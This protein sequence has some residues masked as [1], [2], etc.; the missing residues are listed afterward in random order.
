MARIRLPSDAYSTENAWHLVLRA[1][2]GKPF[3]EPA[4]VE[5]AIAQLSA[6]AEK[7]NVDVL[8]YCFMSDHARLLIHNRGSQDLVQ[9][10]RHFKQRTGYYFQRQTGRKL[11]QKSFFDRGVR[12]DE[13]LQTTA[14]YIRGNPVTD[15]LADEAGQYEWA[16]S[17]EW[18]LA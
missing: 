11:W 17:F 7:Y 12:S 13:D 1:S 2:F 5:P 15:G 16:G 8:T 3:S 14:E 6:S 4:I 9:F 18:N 10:V